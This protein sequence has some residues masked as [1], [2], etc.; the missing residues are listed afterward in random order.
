MTNPNW[1]AISAMRR[2]NIKVRV[3]WGWVEP[4]EAVLMDTP[5]GPRWA[6]FSEGEVVWLPPRQQKVWK[7]NPAGE[8][9]EVGDDWLARR[10]WGP[11]PA[12]WQPIGDRWPDPLPE[13]LPAIDPGNRKAPRF[14]AET[15]EFDAALAAAEMEADRE[16][17]RRRRGPEK[18]ERGL[19][20]WRDP[21][22][23]KY[24]PRG[25]VSQEMAVARVLRAL[26]WCGFGMTDGQGGMQGSRFLAEMC[27]MTLSE[28]LA[29]SEADA[30]GLADRF[31]P[32]KADHEDF[33]EALSWFCRLGPKV[34]ERNDFGEWVLSPEQSVLFWLSRARPLSVREMAD[35]LGIAKSSVRSLVERAQKAA[36]VEANTTITDTA[37]LRALRARNKGHHNGRSAALVL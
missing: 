35:R 25:E 37:E 28:A 33:L 34:R 2:L 30:L 5:T 19:P 13:P 26:S 20:W 17:A 23:I 7:D 18:A 10:G 9:A 15:A 8:V 36:H 6:T 1:Y 12:A 4:F 22:R 27:S 3:R 11:E 24:Q 14:S 29:A 32:V 16:S 31:Q 21:T